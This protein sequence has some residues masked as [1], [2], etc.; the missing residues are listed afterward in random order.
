MAPSK[1]INI[2]DDLLKELEK[3]IKIILESEV[4]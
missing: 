2:T 3:T 4:K 1:Q